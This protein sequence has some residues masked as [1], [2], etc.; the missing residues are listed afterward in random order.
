MKFEIC[1]DCGVSDDNCKMPEPEQHLMICPL[2]NPCY[3]CFMPFPTK[4]HLEAHVKEVHEKTVKKFLDGNRRNLKFI[5]KEL[6]DFNPHPKRRRTLEEKDE[7]IQNLEKEADIK[8]DL[9]NESVTMQSESD[10]ESPRRWRCLGVGPRK[11]PPRVKRICK[12]NKQF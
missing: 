1:D 5:F 9:V 12:T 4:A 2:R 10:S 6:K 3:D 7:T 8:V 11:P